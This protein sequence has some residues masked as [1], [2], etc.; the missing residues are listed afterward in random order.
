[1][2]LWDA[3]ALSMGLRDPEW[4]VPLAMALARGEVRIAAHT[5][6]ELSVGS[7]SEEARKVLTDLF[8]KDDRLELPDRDDFREAGRRLANLPKPKGS[9]AERKDTRHRMTM[10]AILASVAWRRGWAVVTNNRKHFRNLR[11]S[12][13]DAILSPGEVLVS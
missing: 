7:P 6:V 2:N 9:N 12:A 4:T 8:S 3:D 13:E 5:V 11:E 10:D 1:M